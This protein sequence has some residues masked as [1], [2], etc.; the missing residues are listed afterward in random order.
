M[1]IITQPVFTIPPLPMHKHTEQIVESAQ[2]ASLQWYSHRP[3]R[4]PTSM[5][6]WPEESSTEM[7]ILTY[8]YRAVAMT[9]TLQSLATR[10]E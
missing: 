4:G 8:T 3:G 5:P 1:Y 7:K 9:D 10:K 6:P 2:R